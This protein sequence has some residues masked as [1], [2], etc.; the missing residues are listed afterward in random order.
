MIPRRGRQ[1]ARAAR[2]HPSARGV[3]G[4]PATR[5]AGSG[6][7]GD[8]PTL[9]DVTGD[10]CMAAGSTPFVG[11]GIPN[12]FGSPVYWTGDPATPSTDPQPPCFPQE[13]CG[14]SA[15]AGLGVSPLV[16]VGFQAAVWVVR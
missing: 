9:T 4:A 2:G 7:V 8:A 3:A 1:R 10:K 16:S 6:V 12:G 15:L 11:V 14:R 5:P 13:G